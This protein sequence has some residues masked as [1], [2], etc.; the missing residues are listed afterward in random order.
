MDIV[1]ASR[2]SRSRSRSRTRNSTANSRSTS[3]TR[4][5][6]LAHKRTLSASSLDKLV[7]GSTKINAERSIPSVDA[8][9]DNTLPAEF[10]KQDIIALTK[11]LKISKWHKRNLVTHNLTITRISGA[12]TNCI[13]KVEYSDDSQDP[14]PPTL[15]LRIYGK[16]ADELIDRD[17]ELQT[18]IKLAQKRI[19]PR[20]L[21]I[22]TNGRF[23]QFLDGFVTFTKDQI[24]NQIISQIFAR[25]MKDL[26]YKITLDEEDLKPLPT[27]WIMIDK[28]LRVFERD[29]LPGYIEAGID[30]KDIFM[31]DLEQFK[32]LLFDY[33][34]WVLEKYDKSDFTSNYKFCHN[35][36]QYGNLLL[37]E[38]FNPEDVIVTNP[39]RPTSN[40]NSSLN[41]NSTSGESPLKSTSNKKDS[42]LVVIDF[43]YSASNFPAFDIVNHFSEWMANYHDPLKSYFINEKRYP[44]KLEQLN[45]IKSYIEYDFQF[46]SSTLKTSKS[47]QDLLND[48]ATQTA[49]L[50]QY[51][52]EKMYN[53]CVYWR[54]AVQ[55]FWGFWALIQNGPVQPKSLNFEETNEK[56]IDSTYTITMDAGKLTLDD[57]KVVMEEAISS[58]DDDF[59]YIKYAGQKLAVFLGDAIQFGL[60]KKDA[61]EPK[62]QDSVKYLSTETF[63]L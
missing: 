16:N 38:S 63:E 59:D 5:P 23:E 33:K 61:I 42:N 40:P 14:N 19:G 60:L 50:V 4:R 22:F 37:H 34:Y 9:L 32:D 39:S 52:I 26:H 58:S 51:E 18:L 53:E 17:S 2:P 24:R 29:C 3:A 31:M 11:A 30:P 1:P 43:E 54:G 20:L 55:L 28:W 49:D 21:G 44:S 12:L 57:V 45:L 36:T 46:P 15:L 35:D 27:C 7:V 10:F 41:L 8:I 13:Y 6:S 47:A 48:P 62:Y 25:R 56:G